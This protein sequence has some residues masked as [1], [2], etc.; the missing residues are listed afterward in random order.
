MAKNLRIKEVHHF[1][2]NTP[3]TV[4]ELIEFLQTQ[5]PDRIV[6]LEVADFDTNP[7]KFL[8][9]DLMYA[10]RTNLGDTSFIVLCG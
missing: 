4:K 6:R 2:D 1:A 3:T 9:T 10:N 5:E 8:E 7:H